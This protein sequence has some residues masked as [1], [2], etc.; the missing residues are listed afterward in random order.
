NID[1]Q[2]GCSSSFQKTVYT[3]KSG[4][5]SNSD[6]IPSIIVSTSTKKKSKKRKSNNRKSFMWDYFKVIGNKDVCQVIIKKKGRDKK[7]EK[8][9]IHNNS[10]SNMIAHLQSHNIVDNKKL[11]SEA[12]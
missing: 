2:E 11:K 5:E 10:T 3:N 7:C 1:S 9:Y 6:S 4:S 12:Q 8:E